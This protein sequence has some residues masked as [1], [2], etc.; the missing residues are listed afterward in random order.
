MKQFYF[1]GVEIN[2]SDLLLL[3]LQAKVA[4]FAAA[5]CGLQQQLTKPANLSCRAIVGSFLHYV[6]SPSAPAPPP[7]SVVL[8]L[9]DSGGPYMGS[10]LLAVALP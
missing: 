4:C 6:L 1:F 10:I 7:R 8:F 3:G 9:A 5:L 2:Y